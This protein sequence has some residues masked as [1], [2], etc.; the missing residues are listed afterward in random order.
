MPRIRTLK[1]EHRQHRKVGP[2]S[3]RDY[4]LWVS[5]ILEADDTGRFICDASQLRAVTWPYHPR[6]SVAH[7]EE[8]IQAIAAAGMLR[9]YTVAG[10]RYAEWG[11]WGDHQRISHPTDS[12]FP[13]YQDSGA[14]RNNP[15]CSGTLLGELEVEGKGTGRE[16]NGT[17]P[18]SPRAEAVAD[19][20]SAAWPTPEA[21][22]HLYNTL[23]PDNVPT[24]RTLSEKRR[25]RA[26]KLLRQF[27]DRAWWEDTFK[28]Y[29]RSAF[30][31]GRSTPSKGHEG[32][33]PDFDWLLRTGRTA[34]RTS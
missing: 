22:T 1:P 16:G 25:D 7:V 24:V 21:L 4:R 8:S 28:R 23:T 33:R 27:P 10:V 2:L 30:L 12:I 26:K 5:M 3:D 13:S 15:E 19:W 6:V 31:S 20:S 34:R 17:T 29:H 18:P 14:L 9:L 32:F 11:S